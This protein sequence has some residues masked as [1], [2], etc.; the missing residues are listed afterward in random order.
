[1]SAKDSGQQTC[2][3][4]LVGCNKHITLGDA[5]NWLWEFVHGRKHGCTGNQSLRPVFAKPALKGGQQ[6]PP[7]QKC[8]LAFVQS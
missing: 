4:R 5:G 8:R 7:P 3:H 6:T 2:V 1:M